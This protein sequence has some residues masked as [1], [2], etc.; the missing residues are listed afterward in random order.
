MHEALAAFRRHAAFP[1]E[2]VAAPA[3]VPGVEWSDHGSFWEQGYP[4]IM[5][6]DTALYRYPYYHEAGDTPDK[7]DYEQ[8][9]RV[10]QGLHGMTLELAGR[11]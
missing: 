2:G 11:R 3:F 8:L 5:I 9:A 1:S 10:V 6:T 4:A 7:V